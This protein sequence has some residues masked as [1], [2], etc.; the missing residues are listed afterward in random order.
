LR[1]FRLEAHVD[2]AAAL[3]RMRTHGP[4]I[5]DGG[6]PVVAFLGEDMALLGA[7]AGQ[8]PD[9]ARDMR[10]RQEAWAAAHPEVRDAREPFERMSPIT[11]VRVMQALYAMPPDVRIQW[12]RRAIRAWR[13]LL[14]DISD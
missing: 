8:L 4:F 7:Q 6:L 2:V 14:S 3:E 11:R 12:V 9:V 13:G 5:G 10:L 1:I